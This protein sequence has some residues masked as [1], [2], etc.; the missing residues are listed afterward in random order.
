MSVERT[1][2]FS[3]SNGECVNIRYWGTQNNIRGEDSGSC[4]LIFVELDKN[5]KCIDYI[6]ETDGKNCHVKSQGE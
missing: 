1:T 3:C 4:N 6:Q 2:I 5:G